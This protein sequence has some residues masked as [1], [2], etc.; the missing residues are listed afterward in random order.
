M[1][2]IALKSHLKVESSE[3]SQTIFENAIFLGKTIRLPLPCQSISLFRCL[4]LIPNKN[5]PNLLLDLQKKCQHS[6]G[7]RHQVSR[8]SKDQ[9]QDLE[10]SGENYL[11]ACYLSYI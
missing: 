7:G 4:Y 10:C 11:T 9:E 3:N 2:N 5:F 1:P 8:L 6:L